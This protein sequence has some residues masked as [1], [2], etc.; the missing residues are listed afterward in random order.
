MTP[1]ED[2]V[3]ISADTVLD[4]IAVDKLIMSGYSRF[5]VHEPGRP[6]AFIGMLLIRR[7]L[8]YDP[9]D[10]RVVSSF[11]LAILPEA[12]PDINCFQALDYF[13][14]GRAHLLLISRVPGQPEGVLGV[15]TLEDIIEEIIAE[16]IVDE[17]DRYEDNH[18]K[19]MAR[20]KGNTIVMQGIVEHVR[21][22]QTMLGI[23]NG[24][25]IG[26]YLDSAM[27]AEPVS[28]SL[29]PGDYGMRRTQS[30]SNRTL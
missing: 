5:P 24:K 4:H 15:V 20:R 16:E 13:Q 26:N 22:H 3:T 14:T 8:A 18:S 30:P 19:R 6:H 9:A 23:G 21:R 1:I 17:F 7:L 10:R 28:D 2:V 12:G 11:P 25:P 29:A 27:T